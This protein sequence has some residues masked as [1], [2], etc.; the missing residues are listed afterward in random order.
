MAAEAE[1]KNCIINEKQPE[2]H[3]LINAFRDKFLEVC[4]AEKFMF[5]NVWTCFLKEGGGGNKW[6]TT[7]SLHEPK[8]LIF[9]NKP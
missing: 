3:C 1:R 2:Y 9:N 4:V 8:S 5:G 7:Y 6:S